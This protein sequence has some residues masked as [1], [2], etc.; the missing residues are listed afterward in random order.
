MMVVTLQVHLCG[1]RCIPSWTGLQ[2]AAQ[3]VL[4]PTPLAEVRSGRDAFAL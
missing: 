4:P 1:L 2:G 3:H